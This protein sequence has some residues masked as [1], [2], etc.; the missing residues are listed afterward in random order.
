MI[1]KYYKLKLCNFYEKYGKCDKS[2]KCNYAHGKDELRN[3]K[4]EN[5]YN[6]LN[7]FKKKC[8]FT[9]PEGWNPE[10]NK[11][12]CEYYANGFC[13]KEDKC[14]FKHIEDDNYDVENIEI[15]KKD[16]NIDIN[17]NDHFPYFID[18][19]DNIKVN[20]NKEILEKEI[21]HNLNENEDL[22]DNIEYSEDE[23]K[24][25]DIENDS[26]PNI[27]VFVNEIECNDTEDLINIL[28]NNSLNLVKDIKKNID[29]KFIG[30]KE[31]YGINMKLK[32]N[33]IISEINLFKNNYKDI[34]D[35][36]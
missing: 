25:E 33:E 17:D 4:K 22:Q 2:D 3:F 10:N 35:L 8:E 5:C 16:K 31:K 21:S 24:N 23:M 26:S 7:C 6:G 1:D 30:D 20:T 15:N 18:N 32:L 12:I 13:N 27:E 19:K 34:I 36:I 14:K 11:R 9:H 28:Y 29:K